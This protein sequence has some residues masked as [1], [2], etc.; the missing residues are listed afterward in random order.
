MASPAKVA[1]LETTPEAAAAPPPPAPHPA[2]KIP[3]TFELGDRMID[4]AL[5]KNCSF[6]ALTKIVNEARE[7]TTPSS[8]EGKLR[9]ARLLRQVEYSAGGTVVPLSMP[10]V[11]RMPIKASREI[12]D[13]IDKFDGQV[14]KVVRKGDGIDKAIIYELGTPLPGG[15][16]KQPIRELEFIAKTYGEVEDVLAANDPLLAVTY[17]V[18]QVAKPLG[19]DITLTSLP[20]WALERL[21]AADGLAIS[22]EVLPHFLGSP[23]A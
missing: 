4:S 20:S 3:I 18:A 10:D 22:Q 16:G 13:R 19:P 15:Q 2:N 21:S 12:L 5:I 9:R 8:W 14:G 6:A 7:M 17:L 1:K 11:L 23:A